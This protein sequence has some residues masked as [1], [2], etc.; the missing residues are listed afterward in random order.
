MSLPYELTTL[1][2]QA[3][4][5][6]R[7]MGKNDLDLADSDTLMSG[8]GLSEKGFSKAI[9][10]LVTKGYL[11]MGDDRA[12]HLSP[13]GYGAIE[14]IAQY[15]L[16]APKGAQMRQ[17]AVIYDLCAVVPDM[18]VAGTAT[19][20]HVGIMLDE[21]EERLPADDT[22]VV[23]RFEAINGEIS[24]RESNLNISSR[25]LMAHSEVKL[26]P[27][28]GKDKLRLRVEAVQLTGM[29]GLEIAGG[30]YVDLA[31]GSKSTEVKA[32]HAAISLINEDL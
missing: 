8:A 30:M 14:D 22:H 6:L 18:L 12:Y 21:G 24:P 31:I 20:I 11:T 29:D 25:N 16:T 27:A 2:P 19:P 9:K 10:R 5:V 13:K 28:T 32:Y 7:F 3:L 23:L 1:P 4:D 17:N 15:D 26:T